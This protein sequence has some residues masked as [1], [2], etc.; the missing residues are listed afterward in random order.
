[1]AAVFDVQWMQVVS[2]RKL[3]QFRTRGVGDVLP[4]L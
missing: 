2:F 3:V 1:M 4:Q